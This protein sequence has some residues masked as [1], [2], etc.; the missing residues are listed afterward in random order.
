MFSHQNSNETGPI[1]H[2]ST[3]VETEPQKAEV[4]CLRCPRGN[5]GIHSWIGVTSGVDSEP[6]VIVDCLEAQGRGSAFSAPAWR[7]GF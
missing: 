6:L 1:T 2:H 5:V 4:T 7:R 3:D